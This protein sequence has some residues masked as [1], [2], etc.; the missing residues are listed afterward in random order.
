MNIPTKDFG[1]LL[2]QLSESQK[3]FQKEYSFKL[4]TILIT[5]G[6]DVLEKTLLHDAGLVEVERE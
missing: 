5:Q 1:N 4:F 6:I 2:Q 3:A